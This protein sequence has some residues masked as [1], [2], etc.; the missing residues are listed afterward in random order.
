MST[1]YTGYP[2]APL[3]F[4]TQLP[5]LG[6]AVKS[7]GSNA[8]G[9]PLRVPIADQV[10][11][12]SN[13]GPDGFGEQSRGVVSQQYTGSRGIR[14]EIGRQFIGQFEEERQSATLLGEQF[15]SL[16]QVRVW[17]SIEAATSEELAAERKS[18]AARAAEK[19]VNS[20]KP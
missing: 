12:R 20:E 8:P 11:P 3:G 18:S 2:P 19:T 6:G 1:T 17:E 5:G 7:P 4:T 15:S 13:S 14:L 16:L 10:C 9:Q